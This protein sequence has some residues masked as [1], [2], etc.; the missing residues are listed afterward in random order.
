MKLDRL[1]NVWFYIGLL[2]LWTGHPYYA[3]GPFLFC[4]L[5]LVEWVVEK[6]KL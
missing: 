6:V 2:C 5:S 1:F 3:I 4:V